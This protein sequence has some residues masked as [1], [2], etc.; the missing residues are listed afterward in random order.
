MQILKAVRKLP[1]HEQEQL[2]KRINLNLNDTQDSVAQIIEVRQDH[3][4][5]EKFTCPH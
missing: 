4:E 3:Q 5:K 1:K 2:I